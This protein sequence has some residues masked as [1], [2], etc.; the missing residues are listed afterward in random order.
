MFAKIVI[1]VLLL[2]ICVALF[3][4][5]VFMLKDKSDKRRMARAL[6]WRVGLQLALIA[7]LA[8]AASQGWIKPHSID[9]SD[10]LAATPKPTNGA[11]P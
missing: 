7:F 11:Q 2:T 10:P 5:M 9:G 8:L 3:S 6:S 1:I 4:G